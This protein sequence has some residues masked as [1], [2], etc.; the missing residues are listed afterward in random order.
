MFD[1]VES[2]REAFFSEYFPQMGWEIAGRVP[3]HEAVTQLTRAAKTF[4]VQDEED[5]E[6]K[7]RTLLKDGVTCLRAME[8]FE[9]RL[10]PEAAA[11]L[12]HACPA[13]Q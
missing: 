5:W 13:S 3:L 1:Y 11:Q 6:D 10:T 7:M 12:Y 8:E 2:L 4:R 9:G